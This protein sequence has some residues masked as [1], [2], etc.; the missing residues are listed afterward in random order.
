MLTPS[1]RFQ[2]QT[3]LCL[4]MSDFHP[5]TWNPMWS[6]GSILM[7]LLSFML[8]D[9][10]TYGSLTTTDDEKRRFAA[11]SFHF[12][13]KDRYFPKLFPEMINHHNELT[14]GKDQPP[15]I[16]SMKTISTVQQNENVLIDTNRRDAAGHVVDNI[17]PIAGSIFEIW[18]RRIRIPPFVYFFVLALFVIYISF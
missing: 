15:H 1:G 5:E 2:P 16:A 8:E 17:S 18:N 3:K 10:S 12:N 9:R 13:M 6:V 11:E 4:S 14:S 7:G